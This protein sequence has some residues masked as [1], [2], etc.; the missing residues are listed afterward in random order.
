MTQ[1]SRKRLVVDANIAHSAGSSEVPESRY[2]RACLDAILACGHIAVF[3][4]ALREEWKQ[5]AALHAKRWWKSMTARRRIDFAEGEEFAPHL[6][7]A[8][9]FLEHDRWKDALRKDFHLVQSAL[10]TGQLIL[11]NEKEL[12]QFVALACNGVKELLLLH[13]GSPAV[14][15]YA[16][17]SWIK[18]GAEKTSDR[19]IDKW[20]EG[21]L[22]DT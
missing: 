3:S 7:R 19:R 12:P 1:G 15:G 6:E 16:C 22:D 11:S 20:A 10:A 21:H 2:S 13:Y 14:E 8:C 4:S 17:I 9:A 18:A 5:H